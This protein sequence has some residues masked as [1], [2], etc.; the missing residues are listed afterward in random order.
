LLRV[1]LEGLRTASIDR[2][3]LAISISALFIDFCSGVIRPVL[4]ILAREF[5]APYFLVGFVATSYGMARLIVDVPFGS[6]VDTV[7]KRPLLLGGTV[8]YLVGSTVGALATNIYHLIVFGFVRG[9]AYAAYFDACYTLVGDIAPAD[10]RAQYMSINLAASLLGISVGSAIGG[11]LSQE[12]GSHSPFV[13]TLL[14]L[15]VCLAF[16]HQSIKEGPRVHRAKPSAVKKVFELGNVN[17]IIVYL[18]SFVSFFS[19]MSIVDVFLP[20]YSREILGLSRVEVGFVLT[21]ESLLTLFT[22]VLFGQVADRLGRKA[23]LLLGFGLLSSSGWALGQFQNRTI[24]MVMACVFGVSRGIIS[25]VIRAC[26]IDMAAPDRRGITLG[27]QRL[28]CD[29]GA[30]LGPALLGYVSDIYG[31]SSAFTVSAAAS[32]TTCIAT[33]VMNKSPAESAIRPNQK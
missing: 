25:P 22:L 23:S 19:S 21:L 24:Y 29:F 9:L 13:F 16:T 14:V 5:D 17:L 26:V 8:F 3:L 4:P 7:G 15:V 28:F 6:V 30:I 32:A 18:A 31:L 1:E 20:L 27:I 12:W 10:R 33:L 2:R 11:G